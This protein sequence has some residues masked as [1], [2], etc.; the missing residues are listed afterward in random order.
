MIDLAGVDVVVEDVAGV[1]M[2]KNCERK[3]LRC[4]EIGQHNQSGH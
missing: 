1:V 4:S 2:G 3:C